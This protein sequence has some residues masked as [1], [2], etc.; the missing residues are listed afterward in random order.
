MNAA[1][2]SRNLIFLPDPMAAADST[3]ADAEPDALVRH[4]AVCREA[5]SQ[6][7]LAI[8]H[9]MN[10]LT[11]GIAVL[12]EVYL[13]EASAGLPMGEGLELI[14]QST[15]RLQT[16]VRD[17]ER[18]H[19]PLRVE[20]SYLNIGETVRGLLELFMPVLPKDTVIETDIEPE[21]MATC[22]DEA[23]FRHA[24]LGLTLNIRDALAARP[25][26]GHGL[27]VSLRRL[28]DDRAELVLVPTDAAGVDIRAGLPET[29]PRRAD[30]DA[31]LADA[32]LVFE[33][34][35]GRLTRGGHGEYIAE[36]PLVVC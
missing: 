19:G 29:D 23:R 8:V 30:A 2:H 26:P 16:F 27:R 11:G 7:T 3:S 6:L 20:S 22:L 9:E 25:E 15:R 10:S 36:L 34:L 24:L 32:T 21:E 17:L 14:H 18:V 5:C 4:A 31:R 35:G 1:L 33:E 13:Q 28:P 12:S